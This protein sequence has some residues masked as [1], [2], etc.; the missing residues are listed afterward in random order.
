MF[1]HL[2]KSN[3]KQRGNIYEKKT[4]PKVGRHKKNLNKDEKEVTK[5]ITDKEDNET[6]KYYLYIIGQLN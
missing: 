5:N 6:Y 1:Q 2:R 4:R 3:G